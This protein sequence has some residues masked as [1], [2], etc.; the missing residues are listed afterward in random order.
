M[1]FESNT[2]YSQA[3]LRHENCTTTTN[4]ILQASA[5]PTIAIWYPFGYIFVV[6]FK[7]FY[8]YQDSFG[9]CS[10]AHIKSS[11]QW[12]HSGCD[13]VSNHQPR[14]CLLNGL[15]RR[16]SKKT[17]K[18]RVTSFCADRWIPRTNGQL[19]G[20]FFHFMTSSWYIIDI[21][22][23]RK[24]SQEET[25]TKHNN[26]STKVMGYIVYCL[27][28]SYHAHDDVIKWKHFPRYWPFVRGIHR[29]PAWING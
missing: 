23:S 26:T 10:G 12:R 21:N 13:S 24:S 8:A 2:M 20:H 29:S 25:I 11:L 18:L 27:F 3:S 17:S 19:H 15:F 28:G 16:R 7:R 22:T 5:H 6:V 14:D 4:S 9:Y 1:T